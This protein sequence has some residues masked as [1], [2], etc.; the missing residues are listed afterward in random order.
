[1]NNILYRPQKTSYL[2]IFFIAIYCLLATFFAGLA[3]ENIALS[4][5][6]NGLKLPI[7]EPLNLLIV[8]LFFYLFPRF[9]GKFEFSEI[10]WGRPYASLIGILVPLLL[11]IIVWG[12]FYFTGSLIIDSISLSP[13]IISFPIILSLV[14]VLIHGAA[15]QLLINKIGQ[16]VFAQKFG[17]WGGILAAGIM[18]A[19]LQALQGYDSPIYIINSLIFGALLGILAQVFGLMAAA[20]AHGV[21]TWA[22]IIVL[23]Q[24][25]QYHLVPNFISG[26]GQDSYS[27]P[28][29]AIVA[30]AL[31]FALGVLINLNY[32]QNHD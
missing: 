16:E 20:I 9:F 27:S 17:V 32:R 18:F 3:S 1:M 8:F 2:A 28:I 11:I 13:N 26:G 5:T 29:F 12:I 7:R 10:N 25:L 4:A 22:E 6:F 19:A 31:C 24:I 23:P 14:F 30:L 21:W 15:E